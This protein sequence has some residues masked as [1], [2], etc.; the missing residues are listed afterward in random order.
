MK[1][2]HCGCS[3][4]HLISVNNKSDELSCM[5]VDLDLDFAELIIEIAYKWSL[6]KFGLHQT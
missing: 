4:I 5:I 2:I 6:V 1:I 3:M